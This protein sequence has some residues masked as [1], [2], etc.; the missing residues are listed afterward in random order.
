MSFVFRRSV[1]QF[2]FQCY[3]KKEYAYKICLIEEQVISDCKGIVKIKIKKS[4]CLNKTK[5]FSS[6]LQIL[7][8]TYNLRFPYSKM[9]IGGL[10]WQTTAGKI[11]YISRYLHLVC[12]NFLPARVARQLIT[13]ENRRKMEKKRIYLK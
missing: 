1:N 6:R 13:C 11:I 5:M 4:E 7:T 3:T 8:P 9:F 12:V 2:M 10:S